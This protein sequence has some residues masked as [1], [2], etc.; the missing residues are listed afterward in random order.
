MK[1]I[2]SGTTG[3]IGKHLTK[4]LIKDGHNIY[5][6]VRPSTNLKFIKKEKIKFYVF[7]GDINNLISFM[8]K[9]NFDGIIHLASLFLAPHKPKNIKELINSNVLFAASLLEASA[10]SEIPWFINTG[11]FW[12]HY[13]N[14]KYSPVNLYSATKQAFEDIAR[15]YIETSDINFITIKLNDTF[16]PED[17]RAKIFNLWVKISKTKETLDM[18][19]GKQIMDINYIDNIVDGYAQ[20]I[21]LLSN[22]KTNK[23]TGKSFAIKSNP[24]ISLRKLA[25]VFEQATQ[26]KL[27]INW[28]KK[29]YRPREVMIPWK[30]GKSI[31]GWKPKISI[32]EGIKKTFNDSKYYGKQK[33]T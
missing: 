25:S 1:L 17:T 22:D 7:D 2:I 4:R 24:R 14:K 29:E 26:T 28:G 19:P 3:F 33:T 11:T 20:M 31:P 10:K 12:Q 9:E 8:Q 15:Y 6:I 13:R 5:A 23:L 18:S 16:G 27:N 32:E 30:K 21:N